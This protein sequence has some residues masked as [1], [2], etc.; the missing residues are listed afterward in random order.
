MRRVTARRAGAAAG[1]I[2]RALEGARVGVV[3][4]EGVL[5][6]FVAVGM[7]KGWVVGLLSARGQPLA[8]C[9]CSFL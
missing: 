3:T 9:A 5:L 7:L 2:E 4:Q 1:I 8:C 6:L